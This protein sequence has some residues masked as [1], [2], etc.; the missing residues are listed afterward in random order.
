MNPEE[1]ARP[2]TPAKP[3]PESLT[4][5]SALLVGGS[6]GIGRGIADAWAAA[7]ATVTV[8]SRT[9]PTG[10]GAQA[11][12]WSRLD[13]ADAAETRSGLARAAAAE[14]SM[15]CYAAVHYGTRR[16]PFREVAE[17]EWRLQ[18]D[19]N[20]NGLWLTLHNCLPVL[21]RAE[22]AGLFVGVSSEVV[23]NGGPERSGYAATKAACSAL[24]N[25][26]A[27]EEDEERVRIV[28]V[29][30]AGMVDTPGIRRRRS[31]DFDYSGYMRPE[32]FGPLATDLAAR[33]GAG[34][35]GESLVVEADG[36]WTSTAQAVP[37]SQSR[38]VP[39]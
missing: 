35:H 22:P 28:Q 31:A 2:T 24:L 38:T 19:V 9:A 25:S 26:V 12:Q 6:T 4:G 23:Y 14:P 32:S 3:G 5:R 37:V 33:S 15:V 20:L 8:L 39:A 13:L 16:A 30:P 17:E 21:R 1:P 27:Q 18:L 34:H 7:G 10:P 11:L 29:L 36:R